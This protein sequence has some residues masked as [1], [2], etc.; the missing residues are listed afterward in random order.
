M[1]VLPRPDLP[2]RGWI[3]S[4]DVSPLLF[5]RLCAAAPVGHALAE[6]GLGGLE[7][8]ALL[9][10]RRVEQA[11]A[12]VVGG[13]RPLLEARWAGADLDPL[14]RG[15]LPHRDL[16]RRGVDLPPGHAAEPG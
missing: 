5:H 16:A 6:F 8:R 10:D 12:L 3:E 15:R 7:R 1:V 14:R 2:S 9:D 11:G 13:V 4:L